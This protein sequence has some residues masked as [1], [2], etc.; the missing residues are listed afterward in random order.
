MVLENFFIHYK[1]PSQYLYWG[2]SGV[3]IYN[4]SGNENSFRKSKSLTNLTLFDISSHQFKEIAREMVA[5]DTGILLNSSQFIFNIFEFEK[6]PW[7]PSMRKE[8]VEWRVKK[9]FPENLD[10]YVHDFFCLTKKRVISVLFKKEIREKLETLFEENNIPLIYMG[11]STLEIINQL[12]K[13]KKE[14]PDFFIEIDKSLAIMVFINRNIPYY[15]RKFRFDKEIGL[16][17]EIIKTVN[18]VKNNYSLTPQRYFIASDPSEIDTNL[19]RNELT[20]SELQSIEIK[21]KDQLFFSR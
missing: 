16:V 10:D 13:I 14:A 17:N 15:I 21:P 5:L 12:A 11:N 8:V 18:Y 2:E 4:L 9:I 6:L 3:D 7:Q 20:G 19:I 1:K